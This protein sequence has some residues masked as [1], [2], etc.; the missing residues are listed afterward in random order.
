MNFMFSYRHFSSSTQSLSSP[1]ASLYSLLFLFSSWPLPQHLLLLQV[2]LLV[3]QSLPV[4]SGVSSTVA[5]LTD[6][7]PASPLVYHICPLPPPLPTSSPLPP[8][9]LQ[10]RKCVVSWYGG[11]VSSRETPSLPHTDQKQTIWT[12]PHSQ[13]HR[14]NDPDQRTWAETGASAEICSLIGRHE[15]LNKNINYRNNS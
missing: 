12:K 3:F 1:P 5:L 11:S 7:L 8:H 15:E 13:F 2:L 10:D 14:F 6:W 9:F 4:C